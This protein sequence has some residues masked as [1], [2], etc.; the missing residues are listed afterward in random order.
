VRELTSLDVADPS[1]LTS[2]LQGLLQGTLTGSMV[3]GRGSLRN[4]IKDEIHTS[5]LPINSGDID[6]GDNMN[7]KVFDAT[8]QG[9]MAFTSDLLGQ[10]PEQ[11]AFLRATIRLVRSHRE[12]DTGTRCAFLGLVATS[13]HRTG[14]P[15]TVD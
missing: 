13:M 2:V 5:I 14:A 7:D 9:C 15:E 3:P 6:I 8:W 12:R 1:L 4:A 11:S 10:G